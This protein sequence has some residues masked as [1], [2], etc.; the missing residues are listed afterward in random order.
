MRGF[1]QSGGGGTAV[2]PNDNMLHFPDTYKTPYHQSFS[3]ESQWALPNAPTWNSQDQLV[4]PDGRI[5]F[6]ERNK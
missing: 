3:A 6:D 4:T 2:N 1:W 5:V